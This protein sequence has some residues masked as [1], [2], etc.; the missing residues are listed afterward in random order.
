[1]LGRT[2]VVAKLEKPAAIEHLE[3][4]ALEA[5][6]VMVARVA[7]LPEAAL[8]GQAVVQAPEGVTA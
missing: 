1:M 5:D 6:A 4:I 3:Q 8:A 2:T 7:K